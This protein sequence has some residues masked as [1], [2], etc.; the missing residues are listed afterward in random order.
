MK[1][2]NAEWAHDMRM[3]VQLIMSCA[4]MLE[5]ELSAGSSARTYLKMI[6]QST[7]QL[8]AMLHDML[9]AGDSRLHRQF[10]DVVARAANICA[11]AK[12]HAGQRGIGLVF[13]SN[14]SQ[15]RMRTDGIKYDRI[16]QNLLSNALRFT[17]TGGRVDV[18]VRV[19]G[20]AVELSVKD[21][22]CG[23]PEEEKDRVFVRGV[24]CGGNGYGLAIVKEFTG[25]LGGSVVL[26]S[27][28][29][30]GSCFTV[31]LPVENSGVA[32]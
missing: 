31:R 22:G 3:P 28:V 2:N 29:G 23:I 13:S 11:R 19:L 1:Q 32:S 6:L 7:R 17:P 20:D 12:P 21:T 5:T 24:S 8:Q 9:E 18:C 10:T 30:A 27:K 4:Q 15:F 25:L 26:S 14:A 16:L